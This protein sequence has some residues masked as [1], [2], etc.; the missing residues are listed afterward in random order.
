MA[1][2]PLA[3][4]T[5]LVTGASSGVGEGVARALGAAGADVVVN[6]ASSAEAATRIAGEIAAGGVRA[7][8]VRADVSRED[9]VQAMFRQMAGAWGGIDILVN[10][11]GIQSDAPF[12]EMTIRMLGVRSCIVRPG[13]GERLAR[14]SCVGRLREGRRVGERPPRWPVP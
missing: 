6:Y 14:R 5:A 12:I 10:N 4:Q 8:A 7:M 1:H 2:R 3:G 11:A 9:E 13:H